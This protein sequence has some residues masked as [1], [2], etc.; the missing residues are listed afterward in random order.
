MLYRAA[1]LP[2]ELRRAP[3]EHAEQ[4]YDPAVLG[5]AL[6]GLLRTPPPIDVGHI[7]SPRVALSARLGVLRGLLRRG[8]FSFDDAVRGEDRMTVAVTVFALLEL[9][10]RGEADWEQDEAFGPITVRPGDIPPPRRRSRDRARAADRGAAVPR[11]D[12]VP[13]D[14]LA[15]ALRVEEDEVAAGLRALAVALEGRGLDAARAGGRLDARLAPRRRGGRAAA[16]GAPAHAGAD[17]RPGRDALDRR[18][19]AAGLAARRSRGSAAWR[20]SRRRPRS[21]S[22]G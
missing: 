11:P 7:A 2:P 10:K 19:P 21:P 5:Q 18:L 3:L 13:A 22:A 6:G 1:A 4:A 14:E 8:S 17:A 20:P 12:P 16:A 9:Y 15:D